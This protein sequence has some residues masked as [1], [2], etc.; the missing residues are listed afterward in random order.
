MPGQSKESEIKSSVHKILSLLGEEP[1]R[2]GLKKTPERYAKALS[3]LTA[4][5]EMDPAEIVRKAMFHEPYSEMVII[6]DIEVFSLCEHH[7]LPFYGKAH[8]AYIPDGRIVGLSK[9]PRVVNCFARR[10]QVQERLTDQISKTL[11]ETL[12]P[13]G[14]GVVVECYHLCMMMRGVEKQS[15]YTIT[16]S[17]LGT[18]HDDRRTRQEFM[19]LISRNKV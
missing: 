11:Y 5:Y 12:R 1:G 6:K 14:V 4:G 19:S 16:S 2:E 18:F 10:L 7:L 17:M 15:S 8:I 13:L 3:F 9:I